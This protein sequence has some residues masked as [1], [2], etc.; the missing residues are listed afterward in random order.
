MS[1]HS[2]HPHIPPASIAAYPPLAGFLNDILNA[3]NA[4][5]LL[6]PIDI[7]A[8][9]LLDIEDV[10]AQGLR[11][12]VVYAR[13]GP[14]QEAEEERAVLNEAGNAYVEMLVPFVRRALVEGVY[15]AE[16]EE[17]RMSKG[18]GEALE[19]W[20]ACARGSL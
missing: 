2:V 20:R 12:F 7:M 9:L 13:D 15:A 10:L 19:E 17:L 1:S 5:R 3:L 16:M 14:W 6:A 8:D 11:A 18:L 4:L